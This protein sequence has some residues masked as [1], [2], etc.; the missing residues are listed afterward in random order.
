MKFKSLLRSEK[1]FIRQSTIFMVILI[2]APVF[3]N[4]EFTVATLCLSVIWSI[5][6]LGWNVLGGYAGQV[7]N[8]HAMFFA[9]GA[10]VGALSL[11]WYHISPWISMWIGVAICMLLAFLIGYPL[12]R[13][14]GHYFAIST[15]AIV[16]CVRIIFTNWNFI[17]GAT[18]V[19]FYDKTS[20]SIYTLQFQNRI[21]FYY[22]CLAFMLVFI[23][24]SRVIERS[25]FGYYCRA[26]KAN[27]DSAE[28]AGVNSTFYKRW[29]Y[30]I[31]AGIVAIG[32]ALYAQYIQY[33]DPVSLLPLSNSMLIV[34]VVVMGGIGTI[35]GPVLGAFIMTFINQYARALFNQL[36]GLNLFIYGL[37]VILIVLFLPNGI[38]S[39]FSKEQLAKYKRWL[40]GKKAKTK[41]GA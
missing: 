41:E 21:P 12:L 40:S 9:I 11:K 34:L 3:F 37:L 18:G 30:M 2:L 33:I 22:I 27:Q 20:P 5:M 7:S 17:G 8:G 26:I 28:S 10:Y 4:K 29:A 24:L 38:M 6:G 32:G 16:E 39:L 19:S 14:R 15:M 35:W 23:I 1:G 31:S 13:L 25:K 36:S